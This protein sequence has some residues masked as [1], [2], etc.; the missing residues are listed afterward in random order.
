[1]SIGK[2]LKAWPLVRQIT[3]G[4]PLGLGRAVQSEYSANLRPR[5]EDA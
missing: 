5:T 4:D 1:M 2:R 3:D